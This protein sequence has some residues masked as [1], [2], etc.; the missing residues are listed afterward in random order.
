MSEKQKIEEQTRERRQHHQNIHRR[1]RGFNSCQGLHLWTRRV[2]DSFAPL[3]HKCRRVAGT[4]PTV[5]RISTNYQTQTSCRSE[6]FCHWLV[7]HIAWF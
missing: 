3:E 4:F 2:P 6:R 7:R 5:R 1:G